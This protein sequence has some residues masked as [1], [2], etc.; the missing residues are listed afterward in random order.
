MRRVGSTAC[1]KTKLTQMQHRILL[2]SRQALLP[3]ESVR[4]GCSE[5]GGHNYIA[6]CRVQ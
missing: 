3:Q 2:H 4:Q 1:N 6:C 5:E